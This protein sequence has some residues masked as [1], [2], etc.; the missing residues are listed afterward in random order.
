MDFS[1][2]LLKG[3]IEIIVLKMLDELDEAYGY[4]LLKAIQEESGDVF[5]FQESTLYPLL[6][7][8]EE[9]DYVKS[10]RK[11]APS[12]KERRYYSLTTHGKKLLIGKTTEFKEYVKGMENILKLSKNA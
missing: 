11:K 4:Q 1:K 6:Y 8:L 2:E 3:S 7:R 9:K 10:D 5:S 12:G